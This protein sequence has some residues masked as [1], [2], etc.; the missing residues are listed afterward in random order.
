MEEIFKTIDGFENYEI[1]NLG[2]VR[3]NKTGRFLKVNVNC[4]G[5][6]YIGL[7]KD[8]KRE[9]KRIH[10]LVAETFI[11]K[12]VDKSFV[13]HIDN[14]KLNNSVINLRWCTKQENNRNKSLQ[15]NNTSGTKG[16]VF[17]KRKNQ[18]RSRIT[19]NGVLHH[20]G[21]Y[22]KLEDA[23]QARREKAKELFGEFINECEKIE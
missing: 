6:C 12:I 13:D 7:Q 2:N 10:R 4:W 3:N 20:I 11:K 17:E 14:N 18:W 9:T 8:K 19:I 16:V 21:Y 23:V 5:Y 15:K 1:S 22:D